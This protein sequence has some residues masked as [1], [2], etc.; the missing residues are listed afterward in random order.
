MARTVTAL[1]ED[2]LKYV[3]AI[4]GESM[5]VSD[6][7][8]YLLALYYQS[9]EES[10]LKRRYPFG[11]SE[12]QAEKAKKFYLE[13]IERAFIDKWNKIGA[14][15]EVS[16]SEAGVSRTYLDFEK[17]FLDVVPVAKVI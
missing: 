10:L 5:P 8:A 6:D 7:V 2:E 12:E 3:A 4:A 15:N 9:A 1:T 14:D 17:Y 11:Y 13:N 16:H